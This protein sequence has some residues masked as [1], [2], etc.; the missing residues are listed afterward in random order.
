MT[1]P[2]GSKKT[3][4]GITNTFNDIEATESLET[5]LKTA[6]SEIQHYVTALETENLKLQRQIAKLQA[7][8]I[9]LNSRIVILEENTNEHCVYKTP[10]FECLK[11]SLEQAA[12]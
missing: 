4:K 1:S 9:T 11:K 5:K 6:D 2:K 8:K 7:D 12:A 10:P 3:G